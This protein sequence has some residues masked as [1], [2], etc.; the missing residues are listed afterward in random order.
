MPRVLH[1]SLA[2]ALTLSLFGGIALAGEVP[3]FRD[4]DGHPFEEHIEWMRQ[5]GLTEGLRRRPILPPTT[6]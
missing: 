1:R 2:L 4:V 3:P 6:R 5:A